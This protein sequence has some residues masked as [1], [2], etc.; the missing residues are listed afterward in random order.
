LSREKSQNIVNKEIAERIRLL[1]KYYGSQRRLVKELG[2]HKNT[3]SNWVKG[4]HKPDS[5]SLRLI[6][7]ATG[8]S[9]EWLSRGEGEMYPRRHQEYYSI[10]PKTED[11]TLLPGDVHELG[12]GRQV[13]VVGMVHAGIWA[14]ANDGGYPPGA[15]SDYVITDLPGKNLFAVRV[16]GDSMKPEFQ[17]GD[18]IIIDPD[19]EPKPGDYIL[20]KVEEENEATFKKLGVAEIGGKHYVVLKPLNRDYEDQLIEPDQVRLI[21]KVVERKT[22]Y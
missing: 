6:S 15:A 2:V 19:L 10:K 1:V 16:E 13:P 14:E 21:G 12:H 4:R 20:A 3:L 9:L 11:N 18:I 8:V 5:D 7:E 22:L 17:E